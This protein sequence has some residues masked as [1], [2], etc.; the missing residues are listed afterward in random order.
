MCPKHMDLVAWTQAAGMI[1]AAQATPAVV[2]R[3]GQA[4]RR[5][6][7]M[8]SAAAHMPGAFAVKKER[9]AVPGLQAAA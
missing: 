7:L 4:A 5:K 2:R 8:D 3:V 9:E 6:A 1:E